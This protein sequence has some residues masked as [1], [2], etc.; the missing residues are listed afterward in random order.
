MGIHGHLK[1]KATTILSVK[2]PTGSDFAV[3]LQDG[4]ESTGESSGNPKLWCT[5]QGMDMVNPISA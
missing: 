1:I 5:I 3:T 4:F 2:L